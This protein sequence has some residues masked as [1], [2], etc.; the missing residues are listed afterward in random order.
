MVHGEQTPN[1]AL[2]EWATDFDDP[3]PAEQARPVSLAYLAGA[4]GLATTAAILLAALTHSLAQTPSAPADR[5]PGALPPTVTSPT[6]APS[7][8]A[9]TLLPER[10]DDLYGPAMK[11]QLTGAGL[12]L[13]PNLVGPPRPVGGS[14]D[15]TLRRL[16]AHNRQIECN[17]F[18][19][20][21]EV[22]TV[23][24]APTATKLESARA[25]LDQLGFTRTEEHGGVRFVVENRAADGVAA[26]E[27]HFLRD[28]LWFATRW[29]GFGP[30][31]YTA[32]MVSTLFD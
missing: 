24:A 12:T 31:G 15:E 11:S 29:R 22:L 5:E 17:W 21:G 28:G 27:S 16:V 8:D 18:G 20:A 26:G 23:V 6:Q 3:P 14:T 32:D 25:R 2:F 9:A 19:E 10:C 7:V 13:T 1:D 4:L 30:S